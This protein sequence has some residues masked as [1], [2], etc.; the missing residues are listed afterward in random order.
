MLFALKPYH[1]SAIFQAKRQKIAE[2]T[3]K[4]R[5]A[6]AA[7]PT[8]DQAA[9][10]AASPPAKVKKEGLAGILQDTMDYLD[11][12]LAILEKLE[13]KYSE[14]V[15]TLNQTLDLKLD[16]QDRKKI[17]KD[18]ITQKK[19]FDDI[20][21]GS[22]VMGD[23]L[24]NGKFAQKGK[25]LK[26]GMTDEESIVIRQVALHAEALGL[27]RVR[28]DS[29]VNARKAQPLLEKAK[30][31]IDE[32][33]KSLKART[34]TVSFKQAKIENA[35][36]MNDEAEKN[37]MKFASFSTDLEYYRIMQ[38]KVAEAKGRESALL[39]NIVI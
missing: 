26:I 7:A 13:K 23:T 14:M 19:E 24:F 25:S 5:E 39:I 3:A 27:G 18:F 29:L 2:E 30:I 6:P 28:V 4:L 22:E 10:G 34:E 36:K 17:N 16:D 15:A 12:G 33:R 11:G 21:K 9:E 35:E 37:Q 38:K 20:A 32:A 8:A 31:E 1:P